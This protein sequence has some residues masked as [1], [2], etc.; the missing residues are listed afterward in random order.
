[1]EYKK[2]THILKI[3]VP[4]HFDTDSVSELDIQD[5][6]A[7]IIRVIMPIVKLGTL[8]LLCGDPSV[9]FEEYHETV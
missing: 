4:L 5:A 2:P 6:L 3:E 7:E 8:K 1:M 9:S